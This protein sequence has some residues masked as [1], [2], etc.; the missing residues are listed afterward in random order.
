M[1]G[2]DTTTRPGRM[3]TSMMATS[4]THQSSFVGFGVIVQLVSG[5]RALARGRRLS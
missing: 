2:S 1:S 4:K 5:H 3:A